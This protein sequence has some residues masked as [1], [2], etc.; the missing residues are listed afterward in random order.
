MK[1]MIGWLLAM[2]TAFSIAIIRVTASLRK[3]KS[4]IGWLLAMVIAFSIAIIRVTAVVV[5]LTCSTNVLYYIGI[6]VISVIYLSWLSLDAFSDGLGDDTAI[7]AAVEEHVAEI[8]SNGEDTPEEVGEEGAEIDVTQELGVP[9][10]LLS[11]KSTKKSKYFMSFKYT[12][13]NMWT[14]RLSVPRR[15]NHSSCW[16][17][18]VR[19]SQRKRPPPTAG[20]CAKPPGNGLLVEKLIHV[21]YSVIRA[22]GIYQKGVARLV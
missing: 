22:K 8:L 17:R 2:V 19:G 10:T 13:R 11:K 21:A 5:T 14:C 6:L 3:M 7:E 20:L 12:C 16:K 9:P 18:D 1:S 15:R 4:M